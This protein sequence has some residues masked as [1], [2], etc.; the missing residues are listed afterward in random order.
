MGTD[1]APATEVQG[2]V[3][4]LDELD[5]DIEIV[6]VGDQAAIEAELTRFGKVSERLSVHH[7]PERVTGEDQ[8]ASVIRRKPQSSIVT[9]LRLQKEGAADAFVSAGSTGAVMATGSGP[10][11]PCA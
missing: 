7:A 10:R 5:P 6:L 3:E 11:L 9:G 2:A 1:H 4:A 8:P